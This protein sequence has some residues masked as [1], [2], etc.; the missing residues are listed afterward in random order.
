VAENLT[1]QYDARWSFDSF[2]KPDPDAG[3]EFV[4]AIYRTL[5]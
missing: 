4:R 3:P 1:A 5:P 2:R